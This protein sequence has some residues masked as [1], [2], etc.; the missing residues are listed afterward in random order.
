MIRLFVIG[1][2][3]STV[4]LSAQAQWV[5]ALWEDGHPPT[6]NNLTAA[7][8]VDANH[9]ITNVSVPQL[10]VY[11]PEKGNG[12]A[13]II[14][15]G[16]GYA[17][18]ASHHEGTLFAQWLN[19]QGTAAFVLKY[20][21]P[22]GHKE[23]PL[24]DAQQAIRYV[25]R[26]AAEW[27]I[28][29]DRIGVAG[30]S[31]GGHLAAT[32]STHFAAPG[33]SARPD[34]AIL[35]YPVITMDIATHGGS[36]INLLGDNPSPADLHVFSNEKQVNADTP[37]TLIFLSDDDKVVLPENSIRYYKALKDN[38]VPAAMYIFPTG[39]HGWGLRADF[40]WHHPVTSLMADWL[41]NR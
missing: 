10:T 8:A 26:R 30:F 16:G 35:F 34:F 19:A 41:K 31:A 37:P 18:L 24:D 5:T 6:S 13:V 9:W 1:L 25:R 21:M 14:C 17:G 3:F 38:D 32:V 33:V 2:L 12:Q 15:P 22:N 29:P 20:R 39:G 11:L 7:E 28:R 27:H 23:V 40:A 36:R 4:S